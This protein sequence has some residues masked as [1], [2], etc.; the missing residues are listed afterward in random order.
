MSREGMG[1]FSVSASQQIFVGSGAIRLG[2][3]HG[4]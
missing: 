3:L 1:Y 4:T 2:K